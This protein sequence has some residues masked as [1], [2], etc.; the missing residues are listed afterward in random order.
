MLT[1]D[2]KEAILKR[3]GL[4][5]PTAAVSSLA[6]QLQQA[7]DKRLPKQ[8]SQADSRP[9]SEK[10]S[11]EAINALFDEYTAHRAAKSLRDADAAQRASGADP[12]RHDRTSDHGL[13]N[14][15]VS[16]TAARVDRPAAA[17]H[18]PGCSGTPRPHGA[19][20]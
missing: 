11:I 17:A 18:A 14:G 1:T 4:A 7:D 19:P 16:P 2:Q 12:G 13:V 6:G 5:L 20:P 10:Q 15:P 3:A 9:F 8:R